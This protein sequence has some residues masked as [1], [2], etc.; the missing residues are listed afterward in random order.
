MQ[1]P[2]ALRPL[3]TRLQFAYLAHAKMDFQEVK[4]GNSVTRANHY[5][6]FR[7]PHPYHYMW[8]MIGKYYTREDL[9]GYSDQKIRKLYLEALASDKA[10]SKAVDAWHQYGWTEYEC[11]RDGRRKGAKKALTPVILIGGAL[12]GINLPEV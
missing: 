11:R 12:L 6:I 9:G 8:D 10:V 5:K 2:L 4:P 7:V 3:E 1:T